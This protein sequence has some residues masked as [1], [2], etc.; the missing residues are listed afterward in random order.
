[1]LLKLPVNSVSLALG[2][3]GVVSV[4]CADY[5]RFPEESFKSFLTPP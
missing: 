5:N 1:M 4:N 3:V 2:G